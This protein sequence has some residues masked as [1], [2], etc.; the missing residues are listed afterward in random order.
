MKFN[1]FRNS[2][3]FHLCGHFSIY[4]GI[5]FIFICA[6][7]SAQ[8]KFSLFRNSLKFHLCG[9]NVLGVKIFRRSKNFWDEENF[10]QKKFLV[11]QKILGVKKFFGVKKFLGVKKIFW[12]G[13]FDG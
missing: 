4:K 11:V 12:R 6:D 2:L 7:M 8:M 13:S 10:G 9:K 1:L 5:P 3:Y